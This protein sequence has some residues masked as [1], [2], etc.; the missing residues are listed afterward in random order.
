MIPPEWKPI[1]AWKKGLIETNPGNAA[2]NL[3]NRHTR[4]RLYRRLFDERIGGARFPETRRAG[5]AVAIPSKPKDQGRRGSRP[6]QSGASPMAPCGH[7]GAQT[8]AG[9]PRPRN[10]AAAGFVGRHGVSTASMDCAPQNRPRPDAQLRR[11]RAA[12]RETASRS[13]GGRRVRGESHSGVCA[14]PSRAGGKP[15]TRRIFR[16][17]ELETRVAGAG[18]FLGVAASRQSAADAIRNRNMAAFCRVAATRIGF[19][20]RAAFRPGEEFPATAQMSAWP[21]CLTGNPFS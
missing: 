18:R 1:S 4:R 9:R 8:R 13:R 5:W 17:F 2:R 16:R 7:R 3:K 20:E 6:S 10:F 14:V 11:N 19:L 21:H 12:D 15:K